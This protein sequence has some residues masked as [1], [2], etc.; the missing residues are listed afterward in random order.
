[1]V[2]DFATWLWHQQPLRQ[3]SYKVLPLSALL[4]Q[5][6]TPDLAVPCNLQWQA[7]LTT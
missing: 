5:E 6:H 3:L 1:V 2:I 4:R 7:G